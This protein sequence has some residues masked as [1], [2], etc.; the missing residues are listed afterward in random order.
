MCPWLNLERR[1]GVPRNGTPIVAGRPCAGGG[2]V[3]LG[4]LSPNFMMLAAAHRSRIAEHPCSRRPQLRRA[5]MI[6]RVYSELVRN[7]YVNVL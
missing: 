3:V 5:T 7:P 4:G 6:L 1:R 2:V